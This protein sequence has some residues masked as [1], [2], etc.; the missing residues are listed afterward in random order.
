MLA[1]GEKVTAELVR[2]FAAEE[3][4]YLPEHFGDRA[5]ESGRLSDARD[6]FLTV[7]LDEDFVHF[8]TLPGYP[9]LA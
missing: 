9:E 1:T 6:L 3:L 8:L 4:V 7:A 2:R 5:H